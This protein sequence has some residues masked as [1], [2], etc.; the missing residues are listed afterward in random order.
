MDTI[1]QECNHRSQLDE[2]RKYSGRVSIVYFTFSYTN[3]GNYLVTKPCHYLSRD[4]PFTVDLL[5]SYQN[6]ATMKKRKIPLLLF[7]SEQNKKKLDQNRT[8]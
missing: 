6:S 3:L 2:F 4:V 8:E 7:S 5:V 1:S